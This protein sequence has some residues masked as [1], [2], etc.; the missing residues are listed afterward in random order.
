MLDL[1]PLQ[2]STDMLCR[3]SKLLTPEAALRRERGHLRPDEELPEERYHFH[4]IWQ[5]I[6]ETM[7]FSLLG[8]V[9]TVRRRRHINIGEVQAALK[10]ELDMG[11][12]AMNSYYVHLQDSQVSLAALVKGRSSSRSLNAPIRQS[13]PDHIFYN[14]RPFYG[15]VE[16]SRNV[17]D[18]PTRGRPLRKPLRESAH[19]LRTALEG[20]YEALDEM[21]RHLGMHVDQLKGLPEEEEVL[22]SWCC[23]GRRS[24][25]VRRERRRLDKLSKKQAV[26]KP[27]T[28]VEE[29][30]E[31]GGKSSKE[32]EK[33]EEQPFA[34]RPSSKLSSNIIE[35]LLKFREDQFLFSKSFATLEEALQSGPGFLDL[36]SGSRGVARKLVQKA[37][38]WVLCFDL[39]HHPSENLQLGSVQRQIVRLIDLGAFLAMGGGPECRSFSTAVTPPCRDLAHPEG[40]PWASSAQKEKMASGNEQLRFVLLLVTSCL[41]K[42]IKFWIENP[43]LSWFWRQVGRL[44][45]AK[46]LAQKGVGDARFDYCRFG[47]R[48]RKRTRLRTNLHLAFQTCFC[49]CRVPHVKL[50]GRCKSR[51]INFTKLAEPYPR[52][53]NDMIAGALLIDTGLSSARRKLQIAECAR[54]STLRIGEAGNPGPRAKRDRQ[55]LPGLD[56]VHLLEPATVNLRARIWQEFSAWASDQFG[57]D[58][59][60]TSLRTPV[61]LVQLFAA[62]GYE[63]FDEGVSLHLYRQLLAHAQRELV[64]LRP[65]MGPAWETVTRWESLEPTVHRPPLPEPLARAM[66]T[67]AI[68]WGWR[69]WAAA[70]LCGFFSACRIGE[71]LKATRADILTP[72]D[73]LSSQPLL[74]LK[75]RSPKTRRRGARVQYATVEEPSVICFLEKIWG[76]FEPQQRLFPMTPA[77]FRTRWDAILRHLQVEKSLKLTPGSVRGGGAVA[78]HRSGTKIADLL[79]RLRLA[80]QQTLSHYLQ[81]MTAASVLPNMSKSTREAII[82]LQGALQFF[83]LQT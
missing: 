37:A 45:W 53:V 11:K 29:L 1:S 46:I 57:E 4:P 22:K 40:V 66:A 70:L 21:L 16:T 25:D 18:D 14:I 35:E 28:F 13:I 80:H 71:I 23:D 76:N 48:W 39:S 5:E 82:V 54:C 31:E 78:L 38:C 26:E 69:L 7:Q 24:V 68:A 2:S 41:V 81:E 19:W 59:F 49:Q 61:V 32:K 50:R 74:F 73:L 51:K 30:G 33:K 62:F 58:F 15:Y 79:W 63:C 55:N 72:S 56:E 9:K 83:I 64:G 6:S 36:F 27:P 65:F 52:G 47:M 12:A 77:A 10:A 43:D 75:V 34:D 67:L 20:D 44:S 3:W 60:N 17:S 8:K 42:G